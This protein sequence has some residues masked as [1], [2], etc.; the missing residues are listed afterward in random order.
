MTTVY[1][2]IKRTWLVL[3]LSIF[4]QGCGDAQSE[5]KL[6]ENDKPA[7]LEPSTKQGKH[8]YLNIEFSHTFSIQRDDSESNTVPENRVWAI[9]GNDI[10]KSPISTADIL[11]NGRA[12]IGGFELEDKFWL[13]FQKL[14][15]QK[16]WVY[17]GTTIEL[18]D[19]RP[20]LS[21][22]EY[23]VLDQE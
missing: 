11:I 9:E 6:A 16:L 4:F 18:G 21:V 3:A 14:Q 17:S 12:S 10:A 8:P 22:T 2:A 13:T 20:T 7:Q 1:P 15:A 5:K 23:V 19:T